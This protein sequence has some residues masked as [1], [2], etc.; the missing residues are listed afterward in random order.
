M[1]GQIDLDGLSFEDFCRTVFNPQTLFEKPEAL[2]GY[3]VLSCTMYILGPSTVAYLSELGAEGI[4]LEVPRLGEPMRHCSPYNEPWFYPVS[5]WHPERGTSPAFQGANNNEFHVTIDYRKPEGVDLFYNLV[6]K[7]DIM[8]WNYRPRTFDKWKIGYRYLKDINPGLIALWEGGF[9]GFGPGRNWAS[10]DI[11]GQAMGGVFSFTGWQA[12]RPAGFPSKHTTWIMDYHS[13]MQGAAFILGMLYHREKVSG[14]GNFGEV[15]QLHGATRQTE[16]AL[17]L[18]GKHG[19]VRMRWGNWDPELCVNAIIQCGKS[20]YPGSKN[21][22]EQEEGYCLVTAYADEDFKKLM[23]LIGAGNLAGKY[24]AHKDRVEA[25]AQEEI[26]AALESWSADKTKEEVAKACD[27]KGVIAQPAMNVNECAN[28][29][30]WKERG[31]LFWYEDA[32]YGDIFT[33][34]PIS[35]M[36]DT[37]PRVKWVHRPA[38]ADNEEIYQRVCGLSSERIKELEASEI[39]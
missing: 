13:G 2:K 33:A 35:K 7:S 27:S 37:P 10:Y 17:P 16:Y 39:I 24:A 6:R 25:R 26:Y 18:W 21:P 11:L 29:D 36:S 31:S 20:S 38:G 9:G 15:S 34:G 19:I 5:R 3:R 23:D 14:L 4:K 28:W 1:S 12:N 22:Q 32:V 30:H 8:V